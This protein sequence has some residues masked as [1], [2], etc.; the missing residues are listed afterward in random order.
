M[1]DELNLPSNVSLLDKTE[2]KPGYIL[3]EDLT[4]L[5]GMRQGYV[6]STMD[7]EKILKSDKI[8]KIR[9]FQ[10]D[11][12]PEPEINL[13]KAPTKEDLEA[14]EMVES[15]RRD[16]VFSPEQDERLR[17]IVAMKKGIIR[18]DDYDQKVEETKQETIDKFG[19][20]LKSAN[21]FQKEETIAV[22]ENYAKSAA[23]LQA[24]KPLRP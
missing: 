18:G 24:S 6:L 14:I 7:I 3:Y 17:Q 23:D 22:I 20:A 1:A 10:T 19:A 21:N 12:T 11:K 5:P 15:E 13:N 8:D 2:L 16:A 9:V 4:A